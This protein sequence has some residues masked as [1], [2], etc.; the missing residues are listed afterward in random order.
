M[1]ALV[2]VH[3]LLRW[4]VLVAGVAA[5]LVGITSWAGLRI[6][7]KQARQSMLIYAVALDIQVLLGIVIWVGEQRWAGGGRQFQFEHPLI[8]LL[9][10]VI[11]HVAA[12]RAR[13][14][15][16]PMKAARLR[17]FGSGLS[18]LLILAGIPW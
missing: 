6:E 5:L 14:S 16:D 1:D 7:A 10:L 9:A 8:M 3:S 17:T 11:A 2:S 4:L 13:R 18:L 15:A 12:S